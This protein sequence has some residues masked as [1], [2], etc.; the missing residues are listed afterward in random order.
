VNAV[1]PGSIMFPG[2]SWDS[3]RQENPDDFAAFVGTQFPLGRHEEVAEVVAFL[4]SDRASWVTGANIVVD[5]GQR[6][7]SARRF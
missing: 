4:L 1:S 7:A 5:G 2:G 3:F 6:C